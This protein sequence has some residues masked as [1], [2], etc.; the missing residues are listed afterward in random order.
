MDGGGHRWPLTTVHA[1]IP[2]HSAVGKACEQP[3]CTQ[4]LLP[5]VL[6]LLLLLLNVVQLQRTQA[7]AAPA[8]AIPLSHLLLPP[9]LSHQLLKLLDFMLIALAL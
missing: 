1:C 8:R 6:Q 7:G 9:Q 5:Y 2:V 3:S 4:E